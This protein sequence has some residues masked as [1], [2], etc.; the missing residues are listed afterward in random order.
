MKQFTVEEVSLHD[1]EDDAWIII[2]NFVY[3]ITDF[4][5]EHPGGK[6][7]LVAFAGTDVTEFFKELHPPLILEEY[8]EHYKIGILTNFISDQLSLSLL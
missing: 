5:N 4:L 2:N 3:D 8:G 6:D 1:S 7:I